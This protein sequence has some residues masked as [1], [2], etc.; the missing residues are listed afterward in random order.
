MP[1]KE[2]K[3]PP[4]HTQEKVEGKATQLVG[5]VVTLVKRLLLEGSGEYYSL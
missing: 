4:T 2:N 3:N 5:Q 1:P